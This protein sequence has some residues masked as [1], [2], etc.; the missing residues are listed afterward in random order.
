MTDS[1]GEYLA[2]VTAL[3]AAGADTIWVDDGALDPW[4]VLGAIATLT[5]RARLG[6]LLTSMSHWPAWRLGACAASLARLSRGRLVVRL[7]AGGKFRNHAS[8]L[9]AGGARIFTAGAPDQS[10]DGVIFE[11]DSAD[12]LDGAADTHLEVW[13]AIA[14][15]PDREAWTRTIGAYAA[16]GATGI[17]VPWDPRII[18]LLRGAGE[19]DDRTDLLIATG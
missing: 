6:C 15:P 4:S 17:L 16:A 18:D 3:E 10:A 12:Q 19:P 1:V 9:R 14:V 13:A 5:Q 11:V 7:P 2:D 8:A